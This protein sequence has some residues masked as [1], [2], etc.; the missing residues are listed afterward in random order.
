MTTSNQPFLIFNDTHST[1]KNRFKF[2]KFTPGIEHL[3]SGNTFERHSTTTKNVISRYFFFFL[4]TLISP[5]PQFT[6]TNQFCNQ[7][8]LKIKSAEAAPTAS[9]TGQRGSNKRRHNKRNRA[10]GNRRTAIRRKR[11]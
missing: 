10:K 8:K 11:R 4:Y 3:S 1:G 7:P 6:Q 2:T 9:K 5:S